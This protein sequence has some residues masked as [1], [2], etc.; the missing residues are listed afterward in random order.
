MHRRVI[1]LA[2]HVVT[3]IALLLTGFTAVQAQ[4]PKSLGTKSS[5]PR[6]VLVEL[7]TSEGCSSCPPADALLGRIDG[8]HTESGLLV[9]GVS[10][11]VT[12]WNHEGWTDPFSDLAYTERQNAYG[13]KF[14]LDS[15][16]TPQ[17]VINGNEQIVG[18]DQTALQHALQK[19]DQPPQVSIHIASTSM[20]GDTLTVEFTAS[21]TKLGQSAD[22]FAILADDSEKS[23]VLRGENSGRTLSH[24]S[25]A[26]TI[27]RVASIKNSTQQTV[28]VRLPASFQ[29]SPG[30]HLILFAQAARYGQVLGVDTKPL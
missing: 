21:E 19:E 18:N 11:H 6:A 20:S 4:A 23:T 15:V 29:A 5:E 27:T 1:R 8:K 14:R 17:M 22:I 25:V 2:T 30:H 24:V 3:Q 26:R 16:F 12:Y 7:F 13:E 10:E 28:H 9:V